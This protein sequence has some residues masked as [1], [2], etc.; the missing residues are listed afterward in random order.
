MLIGALRRPSL[1]RALPATS[2]THRSVARI[3]PNN[4]RSRCYSE[5]PPAADISGVRYESISGRYRLLAHLSINTEGPVYPKSIFRNIDSYAIS[6]TVF[7]GPTAR[8]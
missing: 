3:Y 2:E 1:R 4:T 5:G 8:S 7:L 6:Y